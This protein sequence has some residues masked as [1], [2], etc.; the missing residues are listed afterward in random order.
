MTQSRWKSKASWLT[1]L[2]VILLLG[3]TYG[4]WNIIG[5]NSDTFTKVFTGILGVL[6]AF[7]VFNNP[8]EK[9]KF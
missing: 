8:T 6:C 1:V 7:G 4:L 5:M 9:K 2:P 3:D